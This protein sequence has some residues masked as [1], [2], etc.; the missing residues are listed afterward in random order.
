MASS[1]VVWPG[2]IFSQQGASQ[3][4]LLVNGVP[5]CGG[6]IRPPINGTVMLEPDHRSMQEGEDFMIETGKSAK[7]RLPNGTVILLSA[8]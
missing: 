7:I 2:T 5:R 4:I 8:A 3:G 6:G 1:A